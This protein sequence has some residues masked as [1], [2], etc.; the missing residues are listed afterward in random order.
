M[1]WLLLAIALDR[2]QLKIGAF[3]YGAI[4]N[5][6]GAI[7]AVNQ[8][9]VKAP[10]AYRVLVPWLIGGLERVAPGLR[11]YRLVGLYE[12]LKIGFMAGALALLAQ[13]I[14]TKATLIVAL[15]LP[16]TFLFDYW[17]WAVEL[18]ALAAAL[19]GDPWYALA[20]GLVC[21]LS[22]ETALLVPATYFLVTFDWYGATLIALATAGTLMIV[23][24]L[25]GDRGRHHYG[26]WL[27][28]PIN[29]QDIREVR[30]NRPWYLGEITVAVLLS[31]LTLAAVGSGYA[32]RAWPIPLAVLALGWTLARAAEVRVFSSCLIWVALLL[33]HCV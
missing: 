15:L 4:A 21:A 30:V 16:A 1:I 27:M 20:G 8:R 13:A 24:L 18:G 23:R 25:V 28:W 19:T 17:D 33:Q 2:V 10:V 31:L 29:W 12:P 3:N 6:H 11:R 26:P 9:R 5:G 32:G 7:D 14:G 22:R